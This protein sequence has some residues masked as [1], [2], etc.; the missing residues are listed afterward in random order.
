MTIKEIS[1][2]ILPDILYGWIILIT[3]YEQTQSWKLT[4]IVIIN[5]C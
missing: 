1:I 2:T 5:S 3:E 4:K